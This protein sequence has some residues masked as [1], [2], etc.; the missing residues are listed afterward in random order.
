MDN[1][2]VNDDFDVTVGN[3]DRVEM[4]KLLALFKIN[5]LSRK[6]N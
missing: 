2:D 1:K 5:K 4:S 3:R 6:S